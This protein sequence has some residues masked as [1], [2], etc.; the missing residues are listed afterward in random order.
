MDTSTSLFVVFLLLTSTSSKEVNKVKVKPG[1]DAVLQCDGPKDVQITMLEWIRPDL[2]S[3]G[4]VFFYRD[5][6]LYKNYLHQSF[7]DRVELIDPKMKNGDVS[8]ILRNVTD[9]DTGTYKCYVSVSKASRRQ[10]ATPDFSKTI[11][12]LVDDSGEAAGETGEWKKHEHI[13]GTD[14]IIFCCGCSCFGDR[15]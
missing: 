14:C 4:Y 8:V 10:R 15:P 11:E 7:V 12:L 1:E 2:N 9:T 6:R 5:E 13:C 3:D